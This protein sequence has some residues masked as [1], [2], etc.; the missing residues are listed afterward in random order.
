MATSGVTTN[1]LTRDQIIT[2]ALRKLNVIADGQT[3]S[4]DN[5]TNG[6]FALNAIIG[7][8][9]GLGM[10]LW[11]RNE[12]TFS[13]TA[14][15]F[16]YTIGV[17]QTLN[18]PYPVRLMQAYR[19]DSSST[20]RIELD[21][22]AN[23]NY[24]LY[25]STSGGA[26][27]IINYQPKVNSGVIKLWPVPDASAA[28]TSTITIVYTRPIE[29]TSASTDTMDFPEEWLNAIVYGLAVRLAPEWGIPLPDRNLLRQ[30]E[31]VYLQRALENGQE[32]ASITFQPKL[33]E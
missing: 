11:A 5:I 14:N 8:Y 22:Q 3:P 10:Q 26:P 25:P 2:S 23:Y 31:A 29:Y 30:E 12:Y 24:N 1:Q 9:R 15:V 17:G 6:S 28:S 21:I 4:T 18:T 19:V 33:W 7:E 13:L 27:I 20:S 32:D 16:S